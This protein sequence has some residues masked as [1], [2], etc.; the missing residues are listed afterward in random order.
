MIMRKKW[1]AGLYG[2]V[3]TEKEE[4]KTS[5]DNQ[6]SLMKDWIESQ[7]DTELFDVY[8]DEKSGTRVNKRNDFQR[9]LR[10][11]KLKKINLI[12]VK[13]VA[14]FARNQVD[15]IRLAMEL[16][17]MGVRV[18]FY[19]EQIDTF[20]DAKMLGLWSWLA[21]NE[22]R[23]TSER[24]RIGGMESQKKGRFTTNTPPLGYLSVDK[25][26]VINK[27]ESVI[28]EKIFDLFLEGKGYLKIAEILNEEGYRT[29][30]GYPFRS[31]KIKYILKNETYTG[32]LIGNR[33]GKVDMLSDKRIER[34]RSEWV[35][36]KD[37][38]ENIIPQEKFELVQKLIE[39]KSF[40]VGK[41]SKHLFSGV[42]KC[43]LCNTAY[44]IKTE[45][46]MRKSGLVTYKYYDCA[47]KKQKGKCVCNNRSVTENLIIEIVNNELQSLNQN[48][49][50]IEEIKNRTLKEIDKKLNN[51]D[52]E[53]VYINNRITEIE[54][55][56]KSLAKK[57][58]RGIIDDDIFMEIDAELK[59]ELNKLNAKKNKTQLVDNK[60]QF[61]K[62]YD[63]FLE[64]L[65]NFNDVS[66]LSNI[67]VRK[68]IHK[69]EI[70][71][72]EINLEIQLS[73]ADFDI[74][75]SLNGTEIERTISV[76]EY[77]NSCDYIPVV[78]TIGIKEQQNKVALSLRL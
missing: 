27:E 46:R 21:E 8:L 38:H 18:Y 14:R 43:G 50:I 37:A 9:M 28:V 40:K 1:T 20:D 78:S 59:E 29:R 17:E 52:H 30:N 4:Q 58:I 55:E 75:E 11:A 34:P 23:V 64:V 5:T 61:E 33:F 12:V 54:D 16:K 25:K 66:K 19:Q 26:L 31:D 77:K 74:E 68:L 10:D 47:S 73:K 69:I 22:S 48:T 7:P 63:E 72:E 53:L 6:I 67:D 49:N 62:V 13:A 2:R 45:K 57:N 70:F 51:I 3:S 44:M 65:Q 36:V 32:T 71:P 76:E 39:D 42:I 35:I 56:R 15:S 41:R 24:R 60:D